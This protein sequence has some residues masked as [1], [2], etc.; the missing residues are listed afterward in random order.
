MRTATESA[1]TRASLAGIVVHEGGGLIPTLDWVGARA[2]VP[3]SATRREGR[4]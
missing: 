1:Q 2:R 4:R 3:R